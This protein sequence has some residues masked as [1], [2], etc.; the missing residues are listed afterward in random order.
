MNKLTPVEKKMVAD[1]MFQ[2]TSHEKWL[3]QRTGTYSDYE[4]YGHIAFDLND[5]ALCVKEMV[6][7]GEYND[8]YWRSVQDRDCADF[9]AWLFNAENFFKAMAKWIEEGK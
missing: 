4:T 6:K 8:F 9:S 5:A 3:P 2:A 1:W 7:R